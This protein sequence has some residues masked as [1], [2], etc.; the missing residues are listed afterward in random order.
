MPAASG[1]VVLVIVFINNKNPP[2]FVQ[3]NELMRKC[4]FKNTEK[5]KKR[6]KSD[7]NLLWKKMFISKNSKTTCNF[8]VYVVK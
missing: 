8:I 5:T 1:N 6:I 4:Q 3:Y 2:S 7:G